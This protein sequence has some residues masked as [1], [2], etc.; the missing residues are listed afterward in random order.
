MA[1]IAT[2]WPDHHAAAT[3]ISTAAMISPRCCMSGSSSVA[4]TASSMPK[5]AHTMPPRAVRGELMRFRPRMNSR[6]AMK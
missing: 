1:V 2:R 4:T 3:P 5:P 6:A